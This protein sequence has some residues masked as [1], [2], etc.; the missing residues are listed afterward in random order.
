M[1]AISIPK[2]KYEA[3]EERI[4]NME[5]QRLSD[6]MAKMSIPSRVNTNNQRKKLT[7]TKQSDQEKE[8]SYVDKTLTITLGR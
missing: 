2:D 6:N 7:R 5:R 4:A 3:E 1:K 8:T